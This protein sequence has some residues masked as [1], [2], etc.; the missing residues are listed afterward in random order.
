[1]FSDI[2]TKRRFIEAMYG[3][4]VG[5]ARMRLARALWPMFT[6][7]SPAAEAAFPPGPRSD[8]H[9]HRRGNAFLDGFPF[10]RLAQMSDSGRIGPCRCISIIGS[11]T[12]HEWARSWPQANLSTMKKAVEVASPTCPVHLDFPKTLPRVSRIETRNYSFSSCTVPLITTPKEGGGADAG[13]STLWWQL[14]SP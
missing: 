7:A 2:G 14:D 4:R 1:M 12:D 10:W 11:R 6:G 5:C 13:P 8:Q 3:S 9:D